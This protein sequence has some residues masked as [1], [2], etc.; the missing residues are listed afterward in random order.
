MGPMTAAA[1]SDALDAET[2]TA[3]AL[4]DD[5]LARISA[6]DGELNAFTCVMQDEARDAARSAD[7]EMRAGRRRG[8]LHGIPVALKDVFETHDAPTTANSHVRTHRTE[9]RDSAVARRLRDAG[10]ILIGKL[11]THEFAT[12]GPARELPFPPARNPWSRDRFTG[13]SS[14]G[15]GAAV[16][17][18]LVP[19]AIG[20]D[21]LGSVRGPA[22]YCG[23]AG[24]KPTFG[25]IDREGVIPLSYS[26]DTC[27]PL[28]WSARDC[29]LVLGE[30]R[31]PGRSRARARPTDIA[32]ARIG[33]IRHFF[34]TD[35][36][37]DADA[38]AAIED[39]LRVLERLGATLVP[40]E[41]APYREWDACCR[42]IMYAE[43][44][45]I[46]ERDL[47]ER[48]HLYAPI[49]RARLFSGQVVSGSEYVQAMRW[50]RRLDRA[51][52]EAMDGL[53]AV[54]TGGTLTAAAPLESL[55]DPPYFTWRYRMVMA[56]FNL[57]GAPA[58]SVCAGFSDAGLPLSI[59]FAGKRFDDDAVL[60]FGDAFERA[61]PWRDRRPTFDERRPS[62]P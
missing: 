35:M 55:F 5:C 27:G 13:G 43:A 40:V 39:G 47:M 24:F 56:P 1:A 22:G 23:I 15:A 42:I 3:Q 4:V 52:S 6:E 54:V 8:R 58:L 21:S 28:A 14:S 46:H 37:C 10:A 20:T 44:F 26:F 17:A 45:A 60:A 16:A 49:T 38:A 53:D 50:R 2:T 32:G 51:Y 11:N 29:A 9:R 41:T 59:Q 19:L 31:E 48:P 7:R 62:L 36:E 18:G 12:G 57:T 34:E 25:L 33:V 30:L 61:T